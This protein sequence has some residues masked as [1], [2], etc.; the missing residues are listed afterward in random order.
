MGQ[1]VSKMVEQSAPEIFSINN[2]IVPN[3][4][5]GGF[6]MDAEIQ[7]AVWS[8]GKLDVQ[9][10]QILGS[11]PEALTLRAVHP[12]EW[13]YRALVIWCFY[14]SP[15]LIK[16]FIMNTSTKLKGRW[17]A[18]HAQPICVGFDSQTLS[19]LEVDVAPVILSPEVK[20]ISC[21][22]IDPPRSMKQI[23][24]SL[25]SELLRESTYEFLACIDTGLDIKQMGSLQRKHGYLFL[26]DNPRVKFLQA[27][28]A[29][30]PELNGV[31]NTM[32]EGGRQT[33]QSA[34]RQGR[35]GAT[36]QLRSLNDLLPS[37]GNTL[38]SKAKRWNEKEPGFEPLETH[39]LIFK[40]ASRCPSQ[41]KLNLGAEVVVEK[42]VTNGSVIDPCSRVTECTSSA[43]SVSVLRQ[44]GKS[45]ETQE[46]IA[47]WNLRVN[48]RIQVSNAVHNN[49]RS[50]DSDHSPTYNNHPNCICLADIIELVI[51]WLRILILF[52]VRYQKIVQ[53]QLFANV[54]LYHNLSLKQHY[55]RRK[56]M[57][58]SAML[59]RGG[60]VSSFDNGWGTKS[61][62]SGI[63]YWLCKGHADVGLWGTAKGSYYCFLYACE[64]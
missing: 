55:G 42:L 58:I 19:L 52:Q 3:G 51:E 63:P 64:Y 1:N 21:K 25:I 9:D 47:I 41:M 10:I 43:F 35:H 23:R 13:E 48:G 12:S 7:S 6:S 44:N 49:S 50:Y 57:I 11:I 59:T 62:H 56:H 17:L 54:R 18:S 24:S 20:K 5:G 29:I 34:S 2:A 45:S 60:V 39:S 4:P 28:L 38:S 8:S 31:M 26:L 30:F 16:S 53:E 27:E 36:V 22:E 37:L 46:W 61:M 14:G 32:F 40:Q 15:F 33:Q